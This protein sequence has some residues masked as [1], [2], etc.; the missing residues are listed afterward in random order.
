[1]QN[2]MANKDQ[3]LSSASIFAYR[4]T[5]CVSLG[6]GKSGHSGPCRKKTF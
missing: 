4:A 3:A 2:R 5:R 6:N 1:M